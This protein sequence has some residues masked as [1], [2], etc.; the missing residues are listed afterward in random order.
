MSVV[1][2][3]FYP[4]SL[5]MFGKDSLFPFTGM[6]FVK[7]KIDL[8]YC[9]IIGRVHKSDIQKDFSWIQQKQKELKQLV[10]EEFSSST[11]FFRVIWNWFSG[12]DFQT[13]DVISFVVLLSSEERTSLLSVGV[14]ALWGNINTKENEFYPLLA[15]EN[16]FFQDRLVDGYP[17]ILEFSEESPLPYQIFVMPKPFLRELPT[18]E[19]LPKRIFEVR[20]DK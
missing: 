6:F 15:A 2:N 18:A 7:E 17:T 9:S 20:H 3:L 14:T 16:N 10:L 4:P 5:C 11:E 12:E 19:M 8:G 1:E 13:G